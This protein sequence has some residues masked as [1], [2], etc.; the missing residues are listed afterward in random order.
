MTAR[1]LIVSD[2]HFGSGHDLLA[3]AAGLERI[4]PELQWADE[5]VING[6]LLELAFASLEA[7]VRAARPFLALADRHVG[8][9]HYVLGNHDHHLVSLAGDQRCF[10]GGL[11]EPAPRPCAVAPASGLLRALCPHV[12]VVTAYPVCELDGLHITHGHHISAPQRLAASTYERLITPLYELMYEIASLPAGRHAQRRVERWFD[13]AAAIPHLPHHSLRVPEAMQTVCRHLG[14]PPGTV[15]FGHT[16][17]PV[18]GV[19]TPDG[20]H[21]LFNSGSWVW[22]HG[23]Q[24]DPR[25]RPGTVLRATGGALELRELLADCDERDLAR[26]AGGARPTRRPRASSAPPSGSTRSTPAT[27]ARRR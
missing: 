27:A 13:G 7:A 25:R 21:R 1:R 9:I 24:H 5:L 15:I 4:E 20:R 26:M 19:M 2:L 14:I 8:R 10:A 17:V 3:S 22:D 23:A 18:D 12:A 16:H 6:D 11:R